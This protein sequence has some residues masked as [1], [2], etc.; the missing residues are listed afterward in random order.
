MSG[1]YDVELDVVGVPADAKTGKAET[2]KLRRRP[3][4]A[5]KPARE[6]ATRCPRWMY[7]RKGE[8]CKVCEKVGS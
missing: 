4:A 7:H 1:D 6:R 8:F 2:E 5:T 3:P